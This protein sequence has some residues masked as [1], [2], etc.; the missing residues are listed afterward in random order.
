MEFKSSFRHHGGVRLCDLLLQELNSEMTEGVKESLY[1]LVLT[2]G[3][4][5]QTPRGKVSN[6]GSRA[7]SCQ[8]GRVIFSVRTA[9][10]LLTIEKHS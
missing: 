5:K 6:G 10:D 1:L 7:R 2:S 3:K 4:S 8:T 9:T